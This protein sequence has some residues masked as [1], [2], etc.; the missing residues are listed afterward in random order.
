MSE[1]RVVTT[2]ELQELLASGHHV[3]LPAVMCPDASVLEKYGEEDRE[4]AWGRDVGPRYSVVRDGVNEDRVVP[5]LG[6]G[7]YLVFDESNPVVSVEYDGE[8]EVQCI[9]IDDDRHIYLTDDFIPTH[10]TSN[11]VFLKST[12]DAMIDTLEKMG[13]KTHQTHVDSKTISRDQEKMFMQNEGKISYTMSTTE[14]PVISY[15][16]MA[17]IPPRNSIVFR[18][19]DSPVWNR[20]ETALPMSWRL[21]K[22]NA[23]R[24]PGKNYSLQTIPTLSSAIDFDVRK[25]QPDFEQML[26]KRKD[27]AL[28]AKEAEEIYKNTFEYSDYDIAQLDPDVYASQIME[29]IAAKQQVDADVMDASDIVN[30]KSANNDLARE[31]IRNRTQEQMTLVAE[32]ELKERQRKRYAERQL[33]RADFMGDCA[34]AI[35]HQY[36][37]DII[38]IWKANKHK[39]VTLDHQQF[40]SMRGDDLCSVHGDKVYIKVSRSD[41]AREAMEKAAADP[42]SRV[43]SEQKSL[44]DFSSYE[45]T[46]DFYKFLV[47]LD[48]WAFSDGVFDKAFAQRLRI[49]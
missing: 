41:N 13:G 4:R 25:N 20:N 23:I 26:Q 18:A 27:Q 40:F 32:H 1:T 17:F 34:G 7:D 44:E 8:E 22:A 47:S 35:N 15:N 6:Y 45:V 29:I 12:D 2:L 36:D 37:G 11:I 49:A 38:A 21:L 31:A 46:D 14:V 43:Y 28:L 30:N 42:Q 9:M 5:Y 19:G 10:N 3:S 48:F 33:S 39:I 16:D 24:Q